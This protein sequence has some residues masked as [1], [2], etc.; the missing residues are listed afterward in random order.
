MVLQKSIMIL[1]EEKTT[2]GW[3]ESEKQGLTGSSTHFVVYFN[4]MVAHF[5]R[6][7]D[8]AIVFVASTEQD[9]TKLCHII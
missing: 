9:Y 1:A 4:I 3:V 8:V 2:A 5:N 7:E 6:D